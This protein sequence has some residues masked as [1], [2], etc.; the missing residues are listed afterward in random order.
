[1]ALR[2]NRHAPVWVVPLLWSGLVVGVCH[3]A[4]S[5]YQWAPTVSVML[6]GVGYWAVETYELAMVCMGP[7]LALASGSALIWLRR[8][9]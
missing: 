5:A 1:M 7:A 4:W 9:R 6:S 8:R 3:S 2:P